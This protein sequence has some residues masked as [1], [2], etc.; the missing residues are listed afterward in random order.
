MILGGAGA[1]VFSDGGGN[2]RKEASVSE[3]ANDVMRNYA[4]RE[5]GVSAKR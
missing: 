3:L 1:A 5:A 2:G 4:P